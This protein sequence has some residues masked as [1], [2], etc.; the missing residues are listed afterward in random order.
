MVC[1]VAVPVALTTTSPK[2]ERWRWLPLLAV[3]ELG[4]GMVVDL[5]VDGRRDKKNGSRE[6]LEV[7]G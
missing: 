7:R 1:G 5:L 4:G 2:K 6:S 3:E